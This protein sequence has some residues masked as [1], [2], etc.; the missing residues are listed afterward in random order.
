MSGTT[1]ET[2]AHTAGDGTDAGSMPVFAKEATFLGIA[3]SRWPAILAPIVV[4]LLALAGWEAVVRWNS[5]P[6]YILP[7][8]LLVGKTLI[9]DWGTL[10]TSLLIT[11][12]ITA[13]A[14][15]AAVVV[16]VTL[17]VLFTQSK[18]LEMSL[19]P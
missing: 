5:I 16:G 10:S 18:W 14:L 8:P 13:M 7:G 4:G 19:F 11:L 1:S 17:A 9:D 6:Y 12:K 15:T 3:H 2:V